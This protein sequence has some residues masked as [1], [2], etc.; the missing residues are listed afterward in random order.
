MLFTNAGWS[1]LAWSAGAGG[2]VLMDEDGHGAFTDGGGDTFH[3]GGGDVTGGKDPGMTGF[4]KKG[5]TVRELGRRVPNGRSSF[6][7][8]SFVGMTPPPGATP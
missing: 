5:R 2:Q 7:E 3:G 8:S 4:E 1:R 6:G